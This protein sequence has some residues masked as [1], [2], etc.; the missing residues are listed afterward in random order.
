MEHRRNHLALDALS[1]FIADAQTG[2]GPF[3]AVY[4]ATSG[5]SEGEIGRALSVGSLAAILS[6]LPGGALVDRLTDKRRA[7]AGASLTVGAAALLFALSSSGTA[8]IG[9]EMLHSFGSAMLGPGIAAVSLA[10]VGRGG[11]GLRLGRNARFAAIGNGVAAAV[12][13]AAGAWWSPRAVFWLTAGFMLPGLMALWTIG[14]PGPGDAVT[15]PA[16]FPGAVPLGVWQ[17]LLA[18]LRRGP[19][20]GFTA[21]VALFHLGNAALL[22]LASAGL[23][24][25]LGSATNLAVAGAVVVPQAIV[26]LISPSVGRAADRH[27]P[28]LVLAIGFAA[29]PL[30][31]LLLGLVSSPVPFI[32][33]QALDGLSAAAFGTLVPLV[34]ADLTRGRNSFN[35]C[36]G[37]F[38]V[39]TGLG[40][41]LSTALGG[42]LAE[43]YGADAAFLTLAGCG[44]GAVL[45]A[46]ATALSQWERP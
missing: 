6:Q 13:G 25:S 28:R 37:L 3:I 5:W 36:L 7:A 41:A 32:A 33:V 23:A 15:V 14:P 34:A 26:A 43:R 29:V 31:A 10:V 35:L 21:C 27:G 18:L 9:A 1:F 44:I 24:Q 11:L 12:L 22:P 38:G 30:R 4:L 45:T 40:A 39:A 16:D 17:D 20:L 2:F 42:I 46:Y 19:V 8:V